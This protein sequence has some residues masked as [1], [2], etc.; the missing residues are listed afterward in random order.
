MPRCDGVICTFSHHRLGVQLNHF[1]RS[2]YLVA[3]NS[4]LESSASLSPLLTALQQDT[5]SRMLMAELTLLPSKHGTKHFI[6]ICLKLIKKT[7]L[8]LKG[9]TESTGTYMRKITAERKQ[10]TWRT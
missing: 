6:D 3:S 9:G 8:A 1:P 5:D 10:G 2:V 7:K 4:L